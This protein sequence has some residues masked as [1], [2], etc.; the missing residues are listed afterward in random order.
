MLLRGGGADECTNTWKGLL[1][2]V[3][4][5]EEALPAVRQGTPRRWVGCVFASLPDPQGPER[6][7][8]ATGL[9]TSFMNE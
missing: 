3:A 9:K 1:K 7:L 2:P 5:P 4:G 6:C 8:H